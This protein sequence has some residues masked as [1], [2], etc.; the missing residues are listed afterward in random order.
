M[1]DFSFNIKT[2]TLHQVIFKI[3]QKCNINCTYCYVYNM[4]DSSWS[5]RENFASD[6]IVQALAKKIKEHVEFYNMKTFH[7]ELHGGE[8]LLY[9]KARLR[10]LLTTMDFIVGKQILRYSIQT[11]GLL[12]DREWVDL[13]SEF[14]VN[15]GISIDGPPSIFSKRVNRRGRDITP[16][17]LDVLENLHIT[18]TNFKPGALAVISDTSDIC[19]LIDWFPTIGICSFDLLLPLGNIITP[20][21][22]IT[23]LASLEEKLIKG[24][25]YWRSLGEGAPR[26]RL[27]ELM[28][29]GFLGHEVA[30]DALGGDLTT[31]CVVE[32]NG[33]IGMSDVT[34]FLGGIYSSDDINIK[35]HKLDVH[36]EHFKVQELQ[37]LCDTCKNCAVVNACGGGYIPDRF[38]GVSFNNPTYYCSVMYGLGK[39]I[40]KYMQ[41]SI[42]EK[43]WVEGVSRV[44]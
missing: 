35:T 14:K 20:P 2:K 27:Y 28:I 19:E 22:G 21:S 40:L 31:L 5:Q 15:V 8:P 37:K 36:S 38:D 10:K 33:A 29:K 9:G 16:N 39:H 18:R 4:G 13:F 12:L 25:E 1:T 26:I 34:R 23:D 7:L 43:A 6:E 17:L 11:N 24:F 42:P 30:L 44:G 32:S 41:Q 3:S